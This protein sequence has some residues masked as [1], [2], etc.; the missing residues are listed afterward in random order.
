MFG[1]E[2][3]RVE[4][5]NRLYHMLHLPAPVFAPSMIAFVYFKEP[6]R[7]DSLLEYLIACS[8]VSEYCPLPV[9]AG[10]QQGRQSTYNVTFKRV[11]ATIVAVEKQYILHILSVFFC[12]SYPACN[13]HAP[14]CHLWLARLYNIFPHYFISDTVFKKKKKKKLCCNK[15]CFDF[16]YNFCP[17]HFSF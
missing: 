3:P 10:C 8:A 2:I 13:A 17:K 4:S 15:M 1:T 6:R 5:E 16:L 7:M 12:L 14:Y 11:A 9:L